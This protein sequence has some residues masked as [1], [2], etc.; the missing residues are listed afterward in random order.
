MTR[1]PPPA[2]RPLPRLPLLPLC[3]QGTLPHEF[4]PWVGCD[5]TPP[6]NLAGVDVEAL[7]LQPP[8]PFPDPVTSPAD[9][10][11]AFRLVA[12]LDAAAAAGRQ[13]GTTTPAAEL[14][15]GPADTVGSGAPP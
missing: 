12:V 14:A 10:P 2:L 1:H 15:Q 7:C 3:A 11:P 4:G 9:L 8:S 5:P 6:A 13:R